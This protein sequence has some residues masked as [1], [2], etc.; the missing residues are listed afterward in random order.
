MLRT[1]HNPVLIAVP[2]FLFP[3]ERQSAFTCWPIA[4]E[5]CPIPAKLPFPVELHDAAHLS[6]RGDLGRV[7]SGTQWQVD[8][9]IHSSVRIHRIV[10][11][12]I[13]HSPGKVAE[14]E[15]G[16]HLIVPD[17]GARSSA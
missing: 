3:G 5:E 14:K 13:P 1:F 9:E 8:P 11:F 16:G 2:T 7:R 4:L 17:M 12:D 10:E 6:V 15:C